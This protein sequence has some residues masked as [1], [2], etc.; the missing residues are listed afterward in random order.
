MTGESN[1]ERK[2]T[3]DGDLVFPPSKKSSERE[4]E[5]HGYHGKTGLTI[6]SVVKIFN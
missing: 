5:I 3:D 4:G 2:T 6:K 1:D